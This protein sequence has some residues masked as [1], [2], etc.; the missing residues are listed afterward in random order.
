MRLGT[1]LRGG[2]VDKQPDEARS[3]A[4][5]LASSSRSELAKLVLGKSTE[6]DSHDYDVA[7]AIKKIE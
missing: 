7:G 5:L 3:S 2:Q 6:L 1:S 4:N